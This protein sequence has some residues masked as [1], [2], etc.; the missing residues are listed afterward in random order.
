MPFEITRT[1][2]SPFNEFFLKLTNHHLDFLFSSVVNSIHRHDPIF[3]G[4]HPNSVD[5][6]PDFHGF[7]SVLVPIQVV[8]I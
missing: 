7:R 1:A 5:R 8:P 2:N 3:P 6:R 4:Y